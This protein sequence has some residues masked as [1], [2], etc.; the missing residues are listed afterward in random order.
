MDLFAYDLIVLIPLCGSQIGVGDT[1]HIV[2][3]KCDVVLVS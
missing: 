2:K 1:L 3:G